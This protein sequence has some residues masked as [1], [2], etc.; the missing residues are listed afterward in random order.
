MDTS[1]Q[2]ARHKVSPLGDW[3]GSAAEVAAAAKVLAGRGW[4]PATAG[5]FSMRVG[6]G[7]V[8]I[9]VSGRDK[10]TL[11]VRDFVL[12]DLEGAVVDGEGAPSAEAALHVQLYRH[13][14]DIRAVLHTHSP[15]QTVAGR[16][17]ARN[18][19]IELAGYELLKAFS[20]IGTHAT[21]VELPVFMNTQD[22]AGLQRQVE[23]RLRRGGR[24]YGYLIDGHGI[25]VWGRS[26]AVALRHLEAFDFLLGCEIELR[27]TRP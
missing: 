24:L 16:L 6:T 1:V 20:G 4:S 14:P 13:D 26:I 11:G 2:L 17:L 22:L 19:A 23:Q 21:S 3:Q 9:T 5:N 10:G 18:G 12:V 25:Y 15:N 8:A 7:F 27:R